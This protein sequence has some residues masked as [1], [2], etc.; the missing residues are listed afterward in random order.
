MYVLGTE[1][2]SSARSLSALNHWAWCISKDTENHMHGCICWGKSRKGTL[3]FQLW[4]Q[5]V[6]EAK[7]LNIIPDCWRHAATDTKSRLGNILAQTIKRTACL[8]LP[9]HKNTTDPSEVVDDQGHRLHTV[10]RGK[11]IKE[12]PTELHQGW[13]A[14][15]GSYLSI[16]GA[17]KWRK[18][19]G[20][21][22]CTHTHAHGRAHM[23]INSHIAH[24]HT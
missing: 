9:K 4:T 17:E 10:S 22:L 19:P 1:S 24:K 8:V 20:A 18:T 3:P 12:K 21:N 13:G 7:T 14:S 11:S 16:E 15:E 6:S 5:I 23:C 2:W